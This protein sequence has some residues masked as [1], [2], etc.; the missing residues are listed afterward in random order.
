VTGPRHLPARRR[1]S[2]PRAGSL[3]TGY[4]GLDLAVAAVLGAALACCA[5]TDRHAAAVLAARFPGVPNLA[6]LTW[7]DWSAV[8]PVDLSTTGFPFQDISTAGQGA[9]IEEGTRSGF[10]S[11][12]RCRPARTRTDSR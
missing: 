8:P 1:A 12:S 3:C 4:G 2:A 5:E 10:A 7:V 11:F 9:G 6:D